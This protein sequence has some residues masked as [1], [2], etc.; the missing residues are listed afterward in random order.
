[1]I[2]IYAMRRIKSFLE[3]SRKIQDRI[4]T[5]LDKVGAYGLK[6][7]TDEERAYLDNPQDFKEDYNEI[8]VQTIESEDGNFAFR[9]THITKEDSN[10]DDGIIT[11]Y[12]GVME[13][14]G[15]DFD[16]DL[17]IN[18][19][20]LMQSNFYSSELEQS[21]EEYIEGLEHE[22]ENFLYE[23]SLELTK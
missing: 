3:H 7:L 16:G 11:H 4:D 8:R 18:E 17:A 23:I 6:S 12:H 19:F 13:A 5:L 1:M 9:M 10:S 2:N 14:K 20:G 21:I 22:Y 15:N